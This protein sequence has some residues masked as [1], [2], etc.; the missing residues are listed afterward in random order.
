MFMR[1]VF[2]DSRATE[3]EIGRM[4]KCLLVIQHRRDIMECEACLVSTK[5]RL[6][7][8]CFYM[9]TVLRRKFES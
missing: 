7:D 1:I 3:G 2:E 8:R 4:F 5:R 6:K 9:A